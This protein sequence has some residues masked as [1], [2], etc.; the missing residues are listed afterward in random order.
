MACGGD[1]WLG[2]ASTENEDEDEDEDKDENEVEDGDEDE[3]EQ[4]CVQ[5]PLQ[6]LPGPPFFS[7]AMKAF[8][9]GCSSLLSDAGHGSPL[10]PSVPPIVLVPACLHAFTRGR[11]RRA[12]RAVLP[13]G[14]VVR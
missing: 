14:L 8:M 5:P 6:P 1:L 3:N 11:P 7:G 12:G 2:E 10:L 13:A 4:L 9:A